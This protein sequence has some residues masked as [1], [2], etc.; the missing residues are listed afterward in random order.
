MDMEQD[1]EVLGQ[2]QLKVRDEG[3]KLLGGKRVAIQYYYDR[4][5]GKL[6]TAET[7]EIHRKME[8]M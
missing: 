8:T 1:G 6:E 2:N 5:Y 3:R 7:A 4:K